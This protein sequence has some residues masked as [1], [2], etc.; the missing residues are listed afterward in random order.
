M[1]YFEKT[2]I[3]AA[4][5]SAWS[6]QNIA[7]SQLQYATGSVALT[8]TNIKMLGGY[9]ASTSDFADTLP[10]NNTIGLGQSISGESDSFVL[11]IRNLGGT[12]QN[13]VGSITFQ[14]R[15]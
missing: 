12:S 9:V 2:Q 7:N 10:V 14:E 4:T 15:I 1:S 3:S 6:W 11:A 5:G 8:D 13:F